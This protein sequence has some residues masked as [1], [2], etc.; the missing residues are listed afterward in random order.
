MGIKNR[1]LIP[2]RESNI[3]NYMYHFYQQ[4]IYLFLNILVLKKKERGHE[5]NYSDIITL[6]VIIIKHL[7]NDYLCQRIYSPYS[8]NKYF[9]V[10]KCILTF[11]PK[12]VLEKES[13]ASCIYT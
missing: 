12:N 13:S 6:Y 2:Q 7:L 8:D 4:N 9:S 1:S 3:W 5:I 10:C 11:S